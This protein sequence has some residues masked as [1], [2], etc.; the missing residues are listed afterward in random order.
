MIVNVPPT[1]V[2]PLIVL[3]V[4]AP[5][6]PVSLAN[7]LPVTTVGL[8]ASPACVPLGDRPASYTVAESAVA[9]RPAATFTVTVAVSGT[10][11]SPMA[12]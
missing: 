7:R 2:V 4:V 6:T 12:V 5:V 11:L 8:P 10:P 1:A 9:C 3:I